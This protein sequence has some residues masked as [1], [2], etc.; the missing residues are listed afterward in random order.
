MQLVLRPQLK[1][2]QQLKIEQKLQL[3]L[4]QQVLQLS[5]KLIPIEFLDIITFEGDADL[6]L[7]EA[8]FPFIML[9]ELN[10]PL[11]KNGN[12][13]TPSIGL[14]DALAE[15]V[16]TDSD[17]ARGVY[18]NAEEIVVDRGAIL[19]G[20]SVCHYTLDNMVRSHTSLVDRV[21][22]DVFKDMKFSPN[23]FFL[24]RLDAALREHDEMVDLPVVG[25][26][27]KELFSGVAENISSLD[28]YAD[29]VSFY[30]AVYKGTS[31][32]SAGSLDCLA[33]DIEQY[34]FFRVL[35]GES[36]RFGDE[37]G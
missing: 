8:S 20:Q 7:L 17:F 35:D 2:Q 22:R 29:L 18:H 34:G 32:I 3:A 33:D 24:A 11:F 27:Q 26:V 9:H 19:V 6:D 16:E 28:L 12:L 5:L 23:Y 21:V 15:E 25:E 31:V 37:R 10:H 14:S 30:R 4:K 1:L 13:Y 36:S